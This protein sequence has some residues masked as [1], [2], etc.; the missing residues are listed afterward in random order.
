M[1]KKILV[2]FL[3]ALV[4]LPAL[5]SANGFNLNGLGSR[6]QAMGGAYVSLAD[7]FSAVF[8]NPAGAAGFTRPVFGFFA[9]DIIP[10]NTYRYESAIPE[11]PFVDAETKTSHH[12]GMLAGF[13]LPVGSRLVFGLGVSTPQL[14]G[15]K[16][17][18]D[19]FTALSNGTS[20]SWMSKVGTLTLSPMVAV[21]VIPA[22]SLG[23]AVNFS[24]EIFN[25]KN[26]AGFTSGA[27]PA[28]SGLVGAPFVDLGQYEESL[29]GWGISATVGVLVK[30][31]K[32]LS[33]GLTV[34][35]PSTAS[36]DGTALFSYASLYDL[37]DTTDITRDLLSPLWLAGGVSYRPVKRLL[38]SAD[39]HW[40][41]WSKVERLETT[42]LDQAWAAI[43]LIDG[44]DVVALDW[45]DTT[46][47]RFGAEYTLNPTT[48]LRAG[49][50]HDPAPGPATTLSALLP[51]HT[52]EVFSAGVGKSLGDLLID[53]G[54]E[55]MAG[56]TR[57]CESL[58]FGLI[59]PMPG[60]YGA[61]AVVPSL[62]VTYKF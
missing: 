52:F 19:D 4:L 49:Y 23:V 11:A 14:Y 8:W 7:D 57:T 37:P 5:A 44:R 20:F 42:F 35:T 62:S 56:N 53:V 40:T 2:A 21:K 13:Y 45:R 47:F 58:G 17:N 1:T 59:A 51:T 9:T 60:V 18:G 29:A 15:T 55:Y 34:R 39:V 25:L 6:A 28:R 16:W 54:L 38:L 41:Q 24:H 50:Y 48:V 43:A 3:A 36:M 12:V 31:A 26:P 33:I 27:R 22:V 61:K 10:T 46:Q 30:P 32:D